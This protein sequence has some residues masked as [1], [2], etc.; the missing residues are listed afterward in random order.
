MAADAISK[1]VVTWLHRK[2][3]VLMGESCRLWHRGRT[4]SHLLG[5]RAALNALCIGVPCWLGT[6]TQVMFEYAFAHPDSDGFLVEVQDQQ[7]ALLKAARAQNLV[8]SSSLVQEVFFFFFGGG[9]T[10]VK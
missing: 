1:A 9:V 7:D 3:S 10:A 5:A 8:W 6:W 4:I 2:T